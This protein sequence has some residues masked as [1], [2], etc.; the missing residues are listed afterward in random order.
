[1]YAARLGGISGVADV[2][3][4]RRSPTISE[5]RGLFAFRSEHENDMLSL[6]EARRPVE[7]EGVVDGE[8]LRLTVTLIS[9]DPVSGIA[10]FEGSGESADEFRQT[11][12]H[13]G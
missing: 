11:S 5:Y 8:K 4:R 3:S 6:F 1:M 9:L 13:A 2:R 12:P 7:F 10:F